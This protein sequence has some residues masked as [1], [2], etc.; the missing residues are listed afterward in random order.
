MNFA[1]QIIVCN[2]D[3]FI[4]SHKKIYIS[5][6]SLNE[7]KDKKNKL[8]GVVMIWVISQESLTSKSFTVHL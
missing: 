7:V 2:Y 3:V 6:R 4:D 1:F 5:Q 8:C